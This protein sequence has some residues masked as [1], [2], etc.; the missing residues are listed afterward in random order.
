[1][2][3][4]LG[5]DD[6]WY[7]QSSSN[8]CSSHTGHIKLDPK[9]ICMP[10]SKLA[11]EHQQVVRD[12]L[13]GGLSDTDIANVLA[14]RTEGMVTPA[15]IRHFRQQALMKKLREGGDKLS[16]AEELV[17]LFNGYDDVSYIMVRSSH[18]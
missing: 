7:L 4:F 10:V 16:A 6:F 1:M 9:L 17:K 18:I 13:T 5:K 12:S 14:V 15:Q 2:A 3:V 8:P 11:E